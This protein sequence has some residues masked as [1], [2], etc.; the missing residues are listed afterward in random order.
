M[1]R[2]SSQ[3]LL[4]SFHPNR[5]GANVAE[6]Q[7]INSSVANASGTMAAAMRS[8]QTPAVRNS[9][10]SR[11]APKSTASTSSRCRKSAATTT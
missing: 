6:V 4:N 2:N 7:S 5:L 11:S 3:H 9:S 8:R 10:S 1:M